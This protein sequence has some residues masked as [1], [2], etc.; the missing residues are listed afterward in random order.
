[1]ACR[2]VK[3]NWSWHKSQSA[4]SG[5]LGKV[6][7]HGD[8][9]PGSC[10]CN[11]W[12]LNHTHLAAASRQGGWGQPRPHQGVLMLLPA[13]IPPNS[14]GLFTCLKLITSINLCRIKAAEETKRRHWR[15][16]CQT[17]LWSRA[18]WDL[19]ITFEKMSPFV[20]EAS[21]TLACS[22]SVMDPFNQSYN[23][24]ILSKYFL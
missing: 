22:N 21:W 6:W 24:N 23:W 18:F 5:L 4:C 17:G 19:N 13:A 7:C 11:W 3:Q 15:G 16:I 2:K 20:S 8:T 14:E 9:C 12:S 10:L 1:M